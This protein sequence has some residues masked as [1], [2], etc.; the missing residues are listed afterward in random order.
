MN[1]VFEQARG[2]GFNGAAMGCINY[3]WEAVSE[4]A[5]TSKVMPGIMYFGN[6]VAAGGAQFTFIHKSNLPPGEKLPFEDKI[7]SFEPF[8]PGAYGLHVFIFSRYSTEANRPVQEF[9]VVP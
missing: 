7:T 4:S 8:A 6:T 3:G 9:S 5:R 2:F 1:G